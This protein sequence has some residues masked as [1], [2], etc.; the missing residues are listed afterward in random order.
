MQRFF[1]ILFSV[2]LVLGLS[3]CDQVALDE[4]QPQQSVAPGDAF[5]SV[6]AIEAVVNTGY[7]RLEDVGRYGQ[8]YILYPDALADNADFVPGANRYNDIVRNI[9]FDHLTTYT[10]PYDG[11]N[12]MNYLIAEVPNFQPDLPEAEATAFKESIQG[13]ARFLRALNYF[14]LM[15]AFAYEPGR[16]VGGFTEGVILRDGPTRTSDDADLRARASNADV[17]NFILSDLDE[18]TTLLDGKTIAKNRANVVAAFALRARVHLYL[19]NWA[20]AEADASEAIS[21]ASSIGASLMDASQVASEWLEAP[22][23]TESIFEIQ[24]TPGTNGNATFSNEA[25]AS[26]SSVDASGAPTFNFQVIPSADVVS[27]YEADD[28]RT[29]IL[30]SIAGA[31]ALR[32]YNNKRGSFAD[33]IPVLRVSEMYLIRAE[34]RLEQGAANVADAISDLNAIRTN[35]NASELDPAD[36]NVA[37]GIQEVLDERRRELVY[38][39]HRWFDLK[40]R[41]L[42]IPKPQTD[43]GSVAYEDRRILAPL[44]QGEVNSNPNLNQNPGY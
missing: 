32:K 2:A 5:S 6:S 36:Y 25:L 41:G 14:D 16:E 35:R 27:L 37:S 34:A 24:M 30:D 43:E 23:L 8:F 9:P 40:R 20:E 11:I 28:A 17:Y 42:D 10:N 44:P 38:E 39:G 19:E 3:A 7:D 18:A 21:R 4:A 1:T 33:P 22:S 31:L 15:R 26:L 13:Q 12:N 29:A